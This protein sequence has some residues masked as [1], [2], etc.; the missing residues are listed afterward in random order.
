[1]RLRVLSDLHREF[2]PTYIPRLDADVII[3]GG[4]IAIKQNTLPWIQEL[5]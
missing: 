4:D 3:P 5:T 2:R 1:M